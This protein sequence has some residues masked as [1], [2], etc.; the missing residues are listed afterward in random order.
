MRILAGSE[1]VYGPYAV[2]RWHTVP[3]LRTQS[4]GEHSAGV[5]YFCAAMTD[6]DPRAQLL[7]AA[8][9]HDRGEFFTGD[10]PAPTKAA[11]HSDALMTLEGAAATFVGGFYVKLTSREVCVLKLADRLDG[12]AYCVS[13]LLRGNRSPS[14]LDAANNYVT[15]TNVALLRLDENGRLSDTARVFALTILEELKESLKKCKQQT[16]DK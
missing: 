15:Y 5:A 12:C 14:F 1:L 3:M 13:E 4:V 7:I 10:I 2:Q 16:A 6:G 8:L 9:E 11:L